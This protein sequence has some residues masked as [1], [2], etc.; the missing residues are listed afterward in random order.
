VEPKFGEEEPGHWVRCLL[1]DVSWPDTPESQPLKAARPRTGSVAAEA[2]VMAAPTLATVIVEAPVLAVPDDLEK[3]EGIGPKISA[4]LQEAG[5]TT[6]AQLANT[7]AG[8]LRQ[9]LQKA[10]SRFQ[11]TDPS[12]WPQQAELAAAGR[13]AEFETLQSQ[14]SSGQHRE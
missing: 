8:Q 1:Y 13:W 12:S 11:M 4:L 10:G 7:D 14:L 3:I 6:F 9:I 2:S 5:I